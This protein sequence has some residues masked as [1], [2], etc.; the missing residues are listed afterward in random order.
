MGLM[1]ISVRSK[2]QDITMK[3][4]ESIPFKDDEI[5]RTEKIITYVINIGFVIIFP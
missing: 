5:Y 1:P 2:I 3:N 4:H